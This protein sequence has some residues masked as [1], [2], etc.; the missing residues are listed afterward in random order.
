MKSQSQTLTKKLK[1][2]LG[3]F[4]AFFWQLCSTVGGQKEL[5]R[6]SSLILGCKLLMHV[7]YCCFPNSIS[8]P[9][10]KECR[11]VFYNSQQ[12]MKQSGNSNFWSLAKNNIKKPKILLHSCDK[13][14]HPNTRMMSLL[15]RNNTSL[16]NAEYQSGHCHI[17]LVFVQFYTPK[18]FMI[19]VL[20]ILNNTIISFIVFFAFW[21]LC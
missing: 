4:F 9:E 21:H 19:H 1:R 20:Q 14:A 12:K 11:G 17:F 10:N 2:C 7:V 13:F 5:R 16:Q 6:S 8:L 15:C 18:L 3:D